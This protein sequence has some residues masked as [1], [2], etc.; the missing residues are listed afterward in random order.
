MSKSDDMVLVKG[1]SYKVPSWIVPYY[2]SSIERCYEAIKNDKP[3]VY[4]A[5]KLSLASEWKTF[6]QIWEPSFC[7]N[8]SWIDIIGKVPDDPEYAQHFW[9]LDFFDIRNCNFLIIKGTE[10]IPLK[11]ALVEAGYALA[12]DKT[13]ITIGDHIS[14]KTWQHYPPVQNVADTTAAA[15]YIID[16]WDAF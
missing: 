14:Y 7:V 3:Q 2:L 8:S 10:T 4:V 5:S 13:V 11:G 15:Q 1:L 12:N 9:L 6:R 16:F